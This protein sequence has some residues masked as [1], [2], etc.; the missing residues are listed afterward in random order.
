MA[1]NIPHLDCNNT[2]DSGTQACANFNTVIDEMNAANAEAEQNKNG[3]VT[4]KD[5]ATAEKEMAATYAQN[6]NAAANDAANSAEI[7]KNAV[8]AIPSGSF[9]REEFTATD[10]QTVFTF[11]TTLVAL[12]FVTRENLILMSDEFMNTTTNI[13][14]TSPANDGDRVGVYYIK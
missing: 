12:M 11:S 9:V 7:A 3:A 2:A 6:A 14:L 1:T 5:E 10:G 13:T 4:A 8:Q